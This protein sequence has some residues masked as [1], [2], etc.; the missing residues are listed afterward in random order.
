MIVESRWAVYLRQQLP[1][2]SSLGRDIIEPRKESKSDQPPREQRGKDRQMK[3]EA[4]EKHENA[5]REK[6]EEMTC[7]NLQNP[8]C[9]SVQ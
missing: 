7:C 2:M 8:R 1:R 3:A 4:D 5:P 9:I 6:K